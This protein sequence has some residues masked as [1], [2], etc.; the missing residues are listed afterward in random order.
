MSECISVSPNATEMPMPDHGG[1]II[2]AANTF[3]I[4]H[5]NWLDLS[6]G[7]SPWSWPCE[8][9]P[10]EPF[11]T[12]P[13]ND[14]QLRE[15]ARK[16]YACDVEHIL[17]VPGAQFLISMIPFWVKKGRVALPSI[18]YRE[19]LNAWIKA[20]H[21]T[22]FYRDPHE[23][24]SMIEKGDLNY[25]VIIN[26]NNPTSEKMSPDTVLA[27][28]SQ[29][30]QKHG[31]NRLLVLDEAF[32]DSFPELA[33]PNTERDSN[34][35]VLRSFGKFFGLAGVRLGF[36]IANPKWLSK[37]RDV[38][39]PWL[40]SHPALWLAS[41]AL[42]DTP[43]INQQRRRIKAQ[44]EALRGFLLEHYDDAMIR[45]SDLFQTV[46]ASADE[47]YRDFLAFA[48]QGILLRYQSYGDHS[49]WLRFGLPGETMPLFTEKATTIFRRRKG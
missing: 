34:T 4:P 8:N 45:S 47:L 28:Q 40:V 31:Q 35:L 23:I 30:R 18:G 19:H 26:P 22:V 33:L 6:T 13:P 41:R 37:F 7:I 48:Q 20:G 16:Y 32:S 42:A 5:E 3:G 36:F 10:I 9:M 2:W 14:D 15:T 46:F 24:F 12:L 27:I 43:W 49:A 39:G 38:H 44:S 21:D 29:L 17:P 1:D 11:R 25:I